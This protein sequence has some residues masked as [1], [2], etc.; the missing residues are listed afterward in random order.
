MCVCVCAVPNVAVF[1]TSLIS[2]FPGRLLGYFL[3]YFEMVPVATVIAGI[4]FV[5]TF[6]MR[7]IYTV[8]SLYFTH[9]SSF[10]ITFLSPGVAAS[11]SLQVPFLLPR[12]YCLRDSTRLTHCATSRK[13]AVSISDDVIE[14]FH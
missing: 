13:V 2:C 5:L 6:H 7:N 1:Y 12:V 14:I 11:I 9:F 3:N 4:T 8:K 10:L